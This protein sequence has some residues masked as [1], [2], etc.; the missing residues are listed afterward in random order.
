MENSKLPFCIDWTCISKKFSYL[1][2]L[3]LC[4]LVATLPLIINFFGGGDG[5]VSIGGAGASVGG[6]GAR[7]G[8]PWESL[9]LSD[10]SDVDRDDEGAGVVGADVSDDMLPPGNSISLKNLR[11]FL[12]ISLLLIS[13]SPKSSCLWLLFHSD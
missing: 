4:V 9:G 1:G 2:T 3:I 10:R 13:R 7:F 12:F 5:L 8:F 11:I 6:L